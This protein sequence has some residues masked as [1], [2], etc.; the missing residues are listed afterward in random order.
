MFVDDNM[1]VTRTGVLIPSLVLHL[2]FSLVR[3]LGAAAEE[4]L[5][6]ET[7]SRAAWGSAGRGGEGSVS[8]TELECEGVLGS[9]V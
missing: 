5:S 7:I 9:S 8:K 4:L 1:D 2:L 3:P 6:P